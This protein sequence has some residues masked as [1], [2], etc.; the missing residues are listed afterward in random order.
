MTLIERI[1]AIETIR[2]VLMAAD[3]ITCDADF[4]EP[5]LYADNTWIKESSFMGIVTPPV[6]ISTSITAQSVGGGSVKKLIPSQF[7]FRKFS[8]IC[9]T[10]TADLYR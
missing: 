10:L 4:C 3:A 7:L 1:K 8:K 2:D 5:V 9:I 6:D